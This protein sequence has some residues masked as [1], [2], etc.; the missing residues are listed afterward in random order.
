MN[1]GMSSD[2]RRQGR[3]RHRPASIDE[4][5]ILSVSSLLADGTTH[6]WTKYLQE[7]R[8]IIA[9]PAA[10]PIVDCHKLELSACS[11]ALVG[12]SLPCPFWQ[13]A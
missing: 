1:N 4:R 13:L 8:A 7:A 5:L 9:S 12:T 2:R 11:C 3:S 10:V 6:S